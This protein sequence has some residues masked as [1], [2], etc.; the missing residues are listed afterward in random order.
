MMVAERGR[1]RMLKRI[2]R[3]RE[4]EAVAVQRDLSDALAAQTK[5]HGLKQRTAALAGDYARAG[6]ASC[7][8]DIARTLGLS[9]SLTELA[10]ISAQHEQSAAQSA[11]KSRTELARLERQQE[12]LKDWADTIER[13]ITARELTQ[14]SMAPGLARQ[15]L[16]RG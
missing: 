3:L 1:Q 6:G 16:N 11:Q 4:I 2:H 12:R 13:D 5:M 9:N 7:G 14:S 8:E 10:S 15:L